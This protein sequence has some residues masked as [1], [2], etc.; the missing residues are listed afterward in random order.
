MEKTFRFLMKTIFIIATILIMA[1]FF[2]VVLQW[3][4]PPS[5][6]VDVANPEIFWFFS[7]SSA[8]VA[9]LL[10]WLSMVFGLFLTTKLAKQMNVFHQINEL[11]KFISLTGLGFVAIHALV[12]LGDQY[13]QTS[14]LQILLPFF[15]TSYLPIAV[16]LG[17]IGFYFFLLLVASFYIRKRI[18]GK[19]WRAIHYFSFGGY[20]LSL[21]HAVFSG[22]DTSDPTAQ[23][24]YWFTAGV[25][26]FLIIY[27]LLNLI[28]VDSKVRPAIN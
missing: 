6:T 28:E 20:F 9:Y 8:F 19:T 1:F 14:F 15:F 17:Q 7:R 3:W 2:V 21:L 12:L 27:R 16:G 11:H 13:I 26:V 25:V 22:T 5:I 24:L 10:L 18:G 23:F 4:D